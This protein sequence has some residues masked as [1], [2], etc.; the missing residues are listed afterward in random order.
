[1]W[2]ATW[3]S[4]LLQRKKQTDHSNLISQARTRV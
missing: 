2:P 4:I 1:V 3:E